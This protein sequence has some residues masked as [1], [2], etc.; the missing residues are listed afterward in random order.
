MESYRLGMVNGAD[1]KAM[2]QLQE[3]H[4]MPSLS[5]RQFAETRHQKQGK[6]QSQ[7]LGLSWLPFVVASHRNF[8]R[9]GLHPT[10]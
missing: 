5:R 9:H 7:C 2:Q 10:F 4:Q 6:E 1:K 8:P 3:F